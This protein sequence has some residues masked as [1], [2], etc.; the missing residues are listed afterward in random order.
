VIG[1]RF[2]SVR[3]WSSWSLVSPALFLSKP[4]LEEIYNALEAKIWIPPGP[5][6]YKYTYHPSQ[7]YKPDIVV[8]TATTIKL[9][10]SVELPCSR[11]F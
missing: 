9:L 5:I 8:G 11:A 6:G 7:R 2:R 3:R 4:R 1:G 10:H